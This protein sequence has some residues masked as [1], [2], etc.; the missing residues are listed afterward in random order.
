[1]TKRSSLLIIL[2]AVSFVFLLAASQQLKAEDT[3]KCPV[4]GKVIKKSEAKG[5]YEYKDT[6]Y[7]FCCENC[8]EAFIKDPE[9]ILNQPSPEGC[10][11]AEHQHQ[12]EEH[13]VQEHEG[14][15]H[16]EQQVQDTAVDPVC[17]MK[18]KKADAKAT[19][20]YKDK[21]YY[22]CMTECKDKFVKNPEKYIK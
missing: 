19:Y 21:T 5:T 17:G 1:M 6:T 12:Q 22:F 7:Y 20:E 3:V 18:I 14:H 2:F 11:Q 10:S 4:S 8:K 16:A 9:K 15:S 13:K